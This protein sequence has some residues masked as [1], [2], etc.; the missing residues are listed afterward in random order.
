MLKYIIR[1]SLILFPVAFGVT[2]I[3]FLIMHLSP[4]DPAR[5]L[6]GVDAPHADIE[7]VRKAMGLDRPIHVQYFR[8]LS[9]IVVGD[10]G[11]SIQSREP[12]IEMIR[13]RLP[14]T[15]ELTAVAMVFSLLIALPAGIISATKQYSVF[16]YTSM[17]G[18]LFWV[19]M[20]GFW[21][22]LMLMLLF[23]LHLGWL[24]IFGRGGIE[25]LILPAV[26][27]GAPQA[28]LIARLARSSMLDVIRQD[29]IKTARAKGL[30][31]GIV[32]VKHALK[33]ALIPVTTIIALRVPILFGGAVV[34]ETIFAWPGMGRLIVRAIF[35]RDFPVV[36]GTVLIIA[37]IVMLA[38]LLA[39]IVYA[40]MDPR[41]KYE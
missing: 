19:S 18:A 36:Q 2:V 27:L 26:T 23:G 33:N 39:D 22:G 40:Y 1:R 14:A 24:P 32:V 5:I 11:R 31:E 13:A 34:T 35:Q 9:K 4:G 17:I 16:D 21:F 37:M 28:A 41:I 38:N 15:L 20:P 29:Y 6:L 7:A 8:W 12:V 10:F 3:V 30:R 25:H